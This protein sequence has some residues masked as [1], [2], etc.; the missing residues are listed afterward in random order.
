MRYKIE[1]LDELSDS[2]QIMETRPHKFTSIFI[3][4]LLAV[5]TS[6]IL[7]ACFSEKEVVV[8]VT[9]TVKPSQQS[10]VVSNHIAGEIK[11][12]YMKNGQIIKKG[13]VLYKTDDAPLQIQKSK[14]EGQKKYL[15]ND[16]RNL[17]KLSKSIADNTNYFK[18]SEE[19]KEYY[20][21]YKSYEAGN[22]VSVE[23]KNNLMSSK[24]DATNKINYLEKLNKSIEDNKNYNEEGSIYSEQF[25]NYKISRKSIEDSIVIL[26]KSK[27]ELQTQ[28]D[29]DEQILQI[30]V[31]IQNNNNGLTKLKSDIKL[32]VIN[33]IDELRLQVKNINSN[34]IKFDEVGNLSK[35]KNKITMLAQIEEKLNLNDEKLK[36]I[37]LNLKEINKNI[38]ECVV[39]SNIDGKLDIKANL[40]PGVMIEIGAIVANILPKS[41][42]YKIELIIPDKDIGNIKKGQEVKYSFSSLPYKEYGFLKG[43]IESISVNSQIDNE[44]GVTFYT[45]EGILKN[46]ILYSHKNEKAV[47][48]PGMT[49]EGRIITRRKNMLYYLLEKLNL[50]D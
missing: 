49:C 47:I 29:S 11:E 21:K 16:V 41:N 25:N 40:E 36:E 34:V 38:S 4:I 24:N 12:L 27:K 50:K 14:V 5:I 8:K 2:R 20:S 45:G 30:D 26:E 37:D 31:E 3:Y 9:G 48:K 35:E 6:F 22:N 46:N 43:S 23:D 19:E 39:K 13:E 10:Y 42:D 18:D 32:Q 7:W 17:V 28:N 15:T 44:K 33:S 1:N